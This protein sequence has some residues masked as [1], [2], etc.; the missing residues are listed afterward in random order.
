MNIVLYMW[1][2]ESLSSQKLCILLYQLVFRGMNL[3][4]TLPTSV[5]AFLC[6]THDFVLA[7]C[8]LQVLVK[9]K[10]FAE[11]STGRIFG[12]PTA[13]SNSGILF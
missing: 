9:R 7:F 13:S 12:G 3:F 5:G 1:I 10:S 4:L 11:D 2:K 8:L 6:F